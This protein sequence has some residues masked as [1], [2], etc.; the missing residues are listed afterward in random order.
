MSRGFE[1]FRRVV[2]VG[3]VAL[4]IGGFGFYAGIVV[5]TGGKVLHSHLKQGFITQ[6]VTNWINLIAL[7]ALTV[8]LWNLIAMRGQGRWAL[9]LAVISWMGMAL[10]Q[11]ALFPLHVI[12]DRGIDGTNRRLFDAPHFDSLHDIYVSLATAQWFLGV[13]FVIVAMY[14]WTGE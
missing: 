7:F 14:Q 10:I 8:F 6:Q 3:A 1:V 4:W 9:R 5:P 11:I 13:F 2:F 12:M